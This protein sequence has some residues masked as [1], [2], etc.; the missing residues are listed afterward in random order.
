MG[1]KRK[2]E[3]KVREIL[4]AK[5][6]GWSAKRLYKCSIVLLVLC[7]S[8][9]GDLYKT[10]AM[11]SCMCLKSLGYGGCARIILELFGITK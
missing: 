8:Q 11:M 7:L 3:R 6:M 10:N 1:K 4:S 5:S 2:V 9:I